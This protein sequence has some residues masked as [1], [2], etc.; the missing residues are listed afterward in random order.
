[1]P[2]DLFLR[3]LWSLLSFPELR[4]AHS[5]DSSL[6]EDGLVNI[7]KLNR[8]LLFIKMLQIVVE[9]LAEHLLVLHR[10]VVVCFT[11]LILVF[12][13]F[14]FHL[15]RVFYKEIHCVFGLVP[16]VVEFAVHG[17]ADTANLLFLVEVSV[18]VVTEIF[19]GFQIANSEELPKSEFEALFKLFKSLH[20]DVSMFG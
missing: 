6:V 14:F 4:V 12:L 19:I 9:V 5:F 17:M 20:R 1:M 18:V 11:D 15:V 7:M 3:R 13:D 2:P 8:D 16:K 10:E